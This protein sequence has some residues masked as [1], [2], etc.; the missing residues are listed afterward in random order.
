MDCGVRIWMR[1][2]DDCGAIGVS[3]VL[4]SLAVISGNSVACGSFLLHMKLRSVSYIY[5]TLNAEIGRCQS[6]QSVS[7]CKCAPLCAQT[8]SS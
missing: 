4:L 7:E 3:K 1:L 2:A 8:G 5:W 6:E